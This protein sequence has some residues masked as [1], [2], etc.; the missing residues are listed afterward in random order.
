MLSTGGI[1]RALLSKSNTKIVVSKSSS[2][3]GGPRKL[4]K[5]VSHVGS[6]S[7]GWTGGY[8]RKLDLKVLREAS[9]RWRARKR[10]C[11]TGSSEEIRWFN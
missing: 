11:G 7:A 10:S 5:R 6:K 2:L 1:C 4:I 8:T 3:D 9:C